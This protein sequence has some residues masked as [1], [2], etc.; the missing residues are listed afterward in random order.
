[1]RR[2]AHE[3]RRGGGWTE[4]EGVGVGLATCRGMPSSSTLVYDPGR[5]AAS[6]RAFAGSTCA[7]T[8]IEL[9]S[10]FSLFEVEY[11][12][13]PRRSGRS[14]C[15]GTVSVTKPVTRLLASRRFP[16]K[17]ARTSLAG[18]TAW[19]VVRRPGKQPGSEG[20][21]IRRRPSEARAAGSPPRSDGGEPRGRQDPGAAGIIWDEHRAA[22]PIHYRRSKGISA[23]QG[24]ICTTRCT[25]RKQRPPLIVRSTSWERGEGTRS[26]RG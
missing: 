13:V 5:R 2:G 10:P 12:W 9:R 20:F 18:E 21:I 24:A 7:G 8:F 14:N 16:G 1:M 6:R 15:G 19:H 4:G 3:S 25:A 26:R 22:R 23:L 17:T 11:D